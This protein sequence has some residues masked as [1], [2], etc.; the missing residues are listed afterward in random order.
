[1]DDDRFEVLMTNIT[2]R[3]DI[4]KTLYL[5]KTSDI[6]KVPGFYFFRTN[7]LKIKLAEEPK[8]NWCIDGEKL[9]HKAR[10]FEISIVKGT[11][12][13]LPKK[14]LHKIFLDE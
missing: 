10:E 13:L 8:K 6:T 3:K 1:M 5:I 2:S 4:L 12:M 7:N 11:K 14:E 9:K